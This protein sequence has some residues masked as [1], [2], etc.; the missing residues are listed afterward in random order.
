MCFG[1]LIEFFFNCF[2]GTRVFLF[3]LLCLSVWPVCLACHITQQRG[4]VCIWTR[5]HKHT[6]TYVH[7]YVVTQSYYNASYIY[8]YT[9]THEHTLTCTYSYDCRHVRNI[10]D[11]MYICI[12]TQCH[13]RTNMQTFVCFDTMRNLRYM[14]Y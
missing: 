2:R 4:C 13:T 9:H 8:I 7:L 5:I 14:I 1:C 10:Y 6:Y 12:Y 11:S 3:S